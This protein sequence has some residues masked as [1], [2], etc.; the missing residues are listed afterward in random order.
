MID[1][2]MIGWEGSGLIRSIWI[3][4]VGENSEIDTVLGALRARKWKASNRSMWSRFWSP[5]LHAVWCADRLA[6]W[7]KPSNL[8]Y[9]KSNS[10]ITKAAPMRLSPFEPISSSSF[11]TKLRMLPKSARVERDDGTALRAVNS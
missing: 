7:W 4:L 3:M 9:S 8:A 10:A 11:I 1:F 5:S 6:Q 2:Q